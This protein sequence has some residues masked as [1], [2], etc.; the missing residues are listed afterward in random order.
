MKS[1][2]IRARDITTDDQIVIHDPKKKDTKHKVCEVYKN[3][4]IVNITF[5]DNRED[6]KAFGRIKAK[7]MHRVRVV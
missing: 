2:A 5:Y 4:K 6:G 3:S 1:R 7:P